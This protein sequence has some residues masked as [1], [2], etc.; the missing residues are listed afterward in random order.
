LA[1]AEKDL[2]METSKILDRDTALPQQS[3]PVAWMYDTTFMDG[4]PLTDWLSLKDP[5]EVCLHDE[6]VRNIRPLYTTPPSCHTDDTA[7][8]QQALE[9]LRRATNYDPAIART[10]AAL[11]ERLGETK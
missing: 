6:D 2:I 8:L 9:A 10:I 4:S 11:R 5:R 7:L 3:Q 1:F